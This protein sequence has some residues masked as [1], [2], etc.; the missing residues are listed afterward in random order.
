MTLYQHSRADYAIAC[1]FE[2]ELCVQS[3]ESAKKICPPCPELPDES[4]ASPLGDS[5]IRF[6]D[7]KDKLHLS[8]EAARILDDIQFLTLSINCPDRIGPDSNKWPNASAA[9]TAKIRT[10]ASWMHKRLQALGRS[11]L[12]H[13]KTVKVTEEELVTETIRLAALVYTDAIRSLQP[14]SRV[15]GDEM[16][17]KMCDLLRQVSSNRWKM[18]PGVFLWLVAVATPQVPEENERDRRNDTG[19]GLADREKQLRIRYLRRKLGTAAQ[20]VGQ[21]QYPLALWYL[22]SYWVVQRWIVEEGRKDGEI[23]T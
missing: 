13:R 2:A 6:M 15:K 7:L 14:I 20:V 17:K 22:R 1:G 8:E 21:E 23:E 3:S 9:N 11:V 16:T 10:T 18:L 5:A 4:L 12:T 19:A